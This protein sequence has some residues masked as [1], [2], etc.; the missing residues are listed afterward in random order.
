MGLVPRVSFVERPHQIDF[1]IQRVRSICPSGRLCEMFVQ[2]C[3]PGPA[4][5]GQGAGMGWGVG[6]QQLGFGVWGVGFV[7]W[8]LGIEC[9]GIWVWGLG[10]RF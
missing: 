5:W 8:S 1:A 10:F 7:V 4:F 3:A 9:L 2:L 6:A